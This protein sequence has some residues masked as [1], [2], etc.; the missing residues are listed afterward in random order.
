MPCVNHCAVPQAFLVDGSDSVSPKDF[1]LAKE[2][3][4]TVAGRFSLGEDK[5]QVAMATFSGWFNNVKARK[6]QPDDNDKCP[7]D[8]DGVEMFCE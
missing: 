3:V 6:R 4:K 8:A 7:P 5:Q 2:F 1:T